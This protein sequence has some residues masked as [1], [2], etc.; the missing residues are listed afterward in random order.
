[1]E[2]LSRGTGEPSTLFVH[3][4]AGS[5]TSTRPYAGRVSGRRTF[6]HIAGHG[7]S[8]PPPAVTYPAL[9]REVWAAADHAEAT[10]VLGISMGAGAVLNGLTHDPARFRAVVLV[11]P[12]ALDRPRT[13]DAALTRFHTLADLVDTGDVGAVADH[14]YAQ[15]PPDVADGA[16][17]WCWCR[18]QAELLVAGSPQAA[19]RQVPHEVPVPDRSALASVSAPV[20]VLAQEDDDVH[21]VDVARDVA[22]SLP[23]AHLEVFGPGGLVWAHRERVRAIVGEFVDQHGA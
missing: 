17:V 11:L 10:S 5:I 15:E 21:P 3:G 12:A 14:L 19:L 22:H 9:S 20:L 16:T 6:V 23:Q 8:A 2:V 4:L 7:A 18:E 13:S 1:L